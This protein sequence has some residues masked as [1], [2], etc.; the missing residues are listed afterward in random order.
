MW[1]ERVYII[2]S[3]KGGLLSYPQHHILYRVLS[4]NHTPIFYFKYI[5]H[6]KW[7]HSLNFHVGSILFL[8][9][10]SI[11]V[12]QLWI[13]YNALLLFHIDNIFNN[14]INKISYKNHQFW[15]TMSVCSMVKG[16]CF[17]VPIGTV[18]SGGSSDEE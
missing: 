8:D 5:F 17:S 18:L 4:F 13:I 9:L 12:V 1:R 7:L 10:N 14:L 16:K 15:H 11:T 3:Q 2:L 6:S